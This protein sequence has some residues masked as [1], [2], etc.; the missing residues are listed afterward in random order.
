MNIKKSI[1]LRTFKK[2]QPRQIAKFV[3]AFFN[4]RIFIV[5]LGRLRVIEG[6]VAIYQHQK[7]DK[8]FQITVSEINRIINELSQAKVSSF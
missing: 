1:T 4:G 6:K 8:N 7:N 3:R 2:Y 5:G